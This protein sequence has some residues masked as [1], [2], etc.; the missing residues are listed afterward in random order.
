MPRLR[1][2]DFN[3]FDNKQGHR[4]IKDLLMKYPR[5]AQQNQRR[6]DYGVYDY[7]DAVA[8]QSVI[9][10][11]SAATAEE[12]TAWAVARHIKR[13]ARARQFGYTDEQ[14]YTF[15]LWLFDGTRPQHWSLR[16]HLSYKCPDFGKAKLTRGANR[17]YERIWA[18]WSAA[19]ENLDVQKMFT[20]YVGT[21]IEGERDY[22]SR[23]SQWGCSVA[24]V[25]ADKEQAEQMVRAV[26]GHCIDQEG[27]RLNETV[28]WK[29]SD[30]CDAV[31]HNQRAIQS[32]AQK[33]ASLQEEIARLEA[34][35]ASIGFIKESI[36]L[37]SV[38]AFDDE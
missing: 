24:M 19:T 12:A 38:A 35:V 27:M 10:E 3:N 2:I 36:E 15:L 17:L 34:Q 6:E 23:R 9:N 1:P 16:D 13:E 25:A 8:L 33:I 4:M 5:G 26:Y 20:Y 32:A 11:S 31:V 21:P 37:Y 7:G 28:D 30:E 29:S 22:Y 14:V 18:S